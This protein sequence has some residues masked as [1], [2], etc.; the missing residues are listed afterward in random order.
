V[1]KGNI[2][3]QASITLNTNATLDGRALA[4]GAAV[5]LD[6]NIITKP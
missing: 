2:L 5:T 6:A 3:A 1:F 4:Q